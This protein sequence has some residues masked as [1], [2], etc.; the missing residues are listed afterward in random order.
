M[1][2]GTVDVEGKLKGMLKEMMKENRYRWARLEESL[3]EIKKELEKMKSREEEWQREQARRK[4]R[5]QTMKRRLE[6]RMEEGIVLRMNDGMEESVEKLK[7]EGRREGRNRADEKEDE[8]E[9]GGEVGVEGKG[10][11]N[12]TQLKDHIESNSSQTCQELARQFNMSDETIHTYL[13]RLGKIPCLHDDLS[14]HLQESHLQ[15][16]IS[17]TTFDYNVHSLHHLQMEWNAISCFSDV[18]FYTTLI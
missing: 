3:G 16:Q 13:H 11:L 1:G 5:I 10:S 17:G 14:E 6:K 7:G 15:I 2:K 4:E 12:E 9:D 8:K 18:N